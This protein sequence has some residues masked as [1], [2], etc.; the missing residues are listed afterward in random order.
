MIKKV[1]AFC[2]SIL[3]LLTLIPTISNAAR[4]EFTYE[5]NGEKIGKITDPLNDYGVYYFPVTEI[6]KAID[7]NTSETYKGYDGA[8]NTTQIVFQD[9]CYEFKYKTEVTVF[10]KSCEKEKDLIKISRSYKLL[11]DNNI[12]MPAFIFE[13]I[14]GE[15]TTVS[16]YTNRIIIRTKNHNEKIVSKNLSIILKVDDYW[17]YVNDEIKLFDPKSGSKPIIR[18]GRTMLPI[19]RV[20]EEFGGSVTWD[21]SNKKVTISLDTNLVVLWVGKTKALVNGVEKTLDVAPTIISGRTM[22]PLRFVSENLAIQL[23]WDGEN[24][25]IALYQGDFDYLPKSYSSY[26]AYGVNEVQNNNSPESE[27]EDLSI[28]FNKTQP[29]DKNGRLIHIGDNISAEGMFSGMVK[30]VQGTKILVYWDTK[31]IFI[32]KGDEEFWALV[33][34]ISYEANQWIEANKVTIKDSRY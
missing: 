13:E 24:Q 27:N 2:V 29:L 20:I 18:Q 1:T 9:S 11:D 23:V 16:L 21:G 19:A 33:I 34:G 5:F 4:V 26:F 14:L 10:D 28:Q 3:L 25:V 6:L 31:S 32:P 7:P 12:F 15:G 8:F 17:M 22:T 30:E